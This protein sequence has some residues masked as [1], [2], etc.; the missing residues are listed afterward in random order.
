MATNF[1]RIRSTGTAVDNIGSY[2]VNIDSILYVEQV[3]QTTSNIFLRA[4]NEE[5][6]G[7]SRI[8]LTHTA[9]GTGSA[10]IRENINE[11]ITAQPGGNPTDLKLP[12]GI[13]ITDISFL[14]S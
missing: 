10:I 3:N 4:N 11:A 7:N 13:N 8:L 14:T 6:T 1:L 9:T 5:G 2:L 12:K